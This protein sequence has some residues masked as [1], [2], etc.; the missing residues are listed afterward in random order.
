MDV[1]YNHYTAGGERFQWAYNSNAPE[2]NHYWAGADRSQWAY[3]SNAPERNIYYWYEGRASDY[4]VANPPDSGGYI[5]NMSIGWAPRFWE[6]MVRKL[7]I[8]SAAM[9]VDEFHVDGFRVDQTASLH[10]YAVIHADGRAADNACIFGAKFLREWTRTMRLVRPHIILLAEDHS[11]WSA[12][13][14]SSDAG[15]LG[16]DA[17]WFAEYYHHLIGDATNNSSRA[18]LLKFAGY[19]DDRPLAMSWFAGTLGSTGWGRVVY[20]ESHDEA[21]NSSYQEN[22]QSVPSARTIMVA[23]NG[24]PLIGETRRLAEARVHFAAGVTLLGPAPPMFFMGEEVGA[25]QPYRYNDFVEFREDYPG[26][27]AGAGAHLFSFYQDL[28]RL[29]HAHPALRSHPID[30][31]YVHDANRVLAFRRWDGEQD[32][33]VMA[34][35][36]NHDFADGYRIQHPAIADGRWHEI[37]NSNA[38]DY[39]GSGLINAGPI[40]AARGSFTAL[41]PANSVVVF[42]RHLVG[43]GGTSD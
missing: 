39:G 7:F 37:F 10:S 26:L 42:E 28:I 4:P 18:R 20:H 6:E 35:L 41:L 14:Q 5:D 25:W 11:G 32:I 15:G 40:E 13:T 29:R 17:A 16:F 30:I 12:V 38:R 43:A 9:L 21:G 19:G 1:V 2:R 31:L 27:R 36:N 33:L 34:S 24:S 3:D 22:G 23:V 8:S